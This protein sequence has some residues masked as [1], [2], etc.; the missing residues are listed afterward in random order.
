MR[1]R[2]MLAAAMP[3][4]ICLFSCHRV[5]PA[6]NP[7]GLEEGDGTYNIDESVDNEGGSL[8]YEIFV[9]S[10]CDSDGDGIGDFA[11]VASKAGYLEDLGVSTVWLM[12]INPSPSYHGYDVSDYYAVNPDYGTMEDFEGM[13][14]TLKQHGIDVIIDMVLNHSS[15]D[16]PWFLQSA[17]D[18]ASGNRSENSKADWYV[19][20][21]TGITGYHQFQQTG[22]Y[23]LGDFSFTMPDFNW[24]CQEFRAEVKKILTFWLEK[25]VSG[26]RF[27]AVR[28]FYEESMPKN[29]EAMNYIAECCREANPSAYLVGENWTYSTDEYFGYYQSGFDSFFDFRC[30]ANYSVTNNSLIRAAKGLSDCYS[31]AQAASAQ[32]AEVKKRNPTSFPSFFISN[33]DMNRSSESLYGEFAK[34]GANLIYM[35]PGTP[36]IY[37]GEE[38]AMNGIRGNEPTDVAR[39]LPMSWGKGH[40]DEDPGFPEPGY[41]YV[42]EDNP[43]VEKGAYDLLADQRSLV[44]HY[45]K[46]GQI[47]NSI[48]WIKQATAEAINLNDRS[49]CCFRLNGGDG[50]SLVVVVNVSELALE[51]DVSGLGISSIYDECD[52]VDLRARLEGGTLGIPGYSL[53]V[54][55]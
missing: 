14:A 44:S 19:W 52:G 8:Y 34:S 26:Y 55:E 32:V 40:E 1:K 43:P 46:L 47:R 24:D 33:H 7:I 31:F 25:G 4:A 22:N 9:R 45:R 11:G 37:Y 35:L 50:E 29:I 3:L 30:S 10:F 53:V 28:Y 51:A 17:Q 27:D 6:L 42:L 23:Y 15:N 38:I 41:E 12:P 16:N 20:S 48:P 13:V 49:L 54:L 21:S 39:R 36:Y 18:F 5:D 2:L